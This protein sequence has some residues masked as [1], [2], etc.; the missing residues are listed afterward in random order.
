MPSVA[1]KKKGT[2]RP[3]ESGS[4]NGLRDFAQRCFM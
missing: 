3:V 4:K 1:T 2:F